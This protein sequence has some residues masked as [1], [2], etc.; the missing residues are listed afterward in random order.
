MNQGEMQIPTTLAIRILEESRRVKIPF[1][2]LPYIL[3]PLA[4]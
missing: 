3:H 1:T 2:A 4:L